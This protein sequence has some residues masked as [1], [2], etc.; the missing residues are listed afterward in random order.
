MG[1]AQLMVLRDRFWKK[2][3]NVFADQV[4]AWVSEQ[5]DRSRIG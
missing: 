5:L 3:A 1:I 4:S 2:V